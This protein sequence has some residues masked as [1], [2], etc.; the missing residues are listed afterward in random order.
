MRSDATHKLTTHLAKNHGTVVVEDLNVGGMMKNHC[1]A[2]SI[3]AANFGEVRRQLEYKTKRY[4]SQLVVVDRW[5]P[6]SQLCSNCGHRQKM[7]LNKRRYDCPECGLSLDRDEN[8]AKNLAASHAVT[9]R[10]N[11]EVHADGGRCGNRHAKKSELLLV[12][13]S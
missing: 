12:S 8:A 3:A 4:G 7:P 1:L 2:A 5:F 10:W 6:S 9:A 11:P 13:D